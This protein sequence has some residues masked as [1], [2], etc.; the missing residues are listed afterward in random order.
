MPVQR[1]ASFD[2]DLLFNSLDVDQNGEIDKEEMRE[3][4]KARARLMRPRCAYSYCIRIP[5]G[6][7]C[8]V[9][10]DGEGRAA[11]VGVPEG[12]GERRR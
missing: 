9:S 4:W 6:A 11:Q 7:A 1:P 8:T 12:E 3:F 5:H 10:D 2:P